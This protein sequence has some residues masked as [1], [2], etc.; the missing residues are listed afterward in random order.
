MNVKELK[1][2]LQDL[3]DDL[4]VCGVG[5][6]GEPLEIYSTRV[7]KVETRRGNK[8]LDAFVIDME[9]KGPSG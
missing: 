3:P 6:F 8:S 7:R 4:L 1:E 2:K 5:H 9:N